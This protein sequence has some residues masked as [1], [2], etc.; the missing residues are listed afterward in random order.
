M[1][2]G[3]KADTYEVIE[4]L[5]RAGISSEHDLYV[6]E[7]VP[8]LQKRRFASII[9][10]IEISWESYPFL[11]IDIPWAAKSFFDLY[12]LSTCAKKM[13][14]S[15]TFGH[16]PSHQC[17]AFNYFIKHIYFGFHHL[18]IN[19]LQWWE[20]HGLLGRSAIAIEEKLGGQ[21]ENRYVGFIYC[22]CLCEDPGPLGDDP[23]SLRWSND[24]QRSFYNGLKSIHGLDRG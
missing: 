16:H 10:F 9:W 11:I 24:V 23:G 6:L 20:R 13:M 18:G 2:V 4:P 21:F 5:I 8:A 22:N 14:V 3:I 17:R 1:S 12:E 15:E 19:N 7:R